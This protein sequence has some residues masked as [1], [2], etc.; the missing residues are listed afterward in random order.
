MSPEEVHNLLEGWTC[1]VKGVGFALYSAD[2]Y[3]ITT[4]EN[5]LSNGKTQTRLT[6]KNKGEYPDI[7]GK[8]SNNKEANRT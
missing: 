1:E 3:V 2:R 6:K 4:F 7:P 8:T 5:A